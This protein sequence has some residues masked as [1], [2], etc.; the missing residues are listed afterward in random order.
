LIVAILPMVF[1]SAVQFDMEPSHDR[2]AENE[3]FDFEPSS[4]KDAENAIQFDFEPSTGK[5]EEVERQL[6]MIRSLGDIANRDM[7]NW[8]AEY[9]Q[10][11]ET[12]R[13]DKNASLC[14]D[15]EKL[16][17][18]LQQIREQVEKVRFGWDTKQVQ[19]QKIH[20]IMHHDDFKNVTGLFKALNKYLTEQEE[21]S[22]EEDIH[23]KQE[24]ADVEHEQHLLDTHPCPCIWGVWADWGQCSKM[25]GG[26]S[27]TRSRE[28][29]K[30]ATNNGDICEGSSFEQTSC[31]LE[32]CAIDCEW[33]MWGEWSDCSKA[34]GDGVLTRKRVHSIFAQYGGQNC[35]GEQ[36]VTQHCNVMDDLKKT[37]A[38]QEQTIKDL[39]DQLY[40]TVDCAWGEWS[41]WSECSKPCGGGVKSK[42]RVI[43]TE[44]KNGGKACSGNSM[45]SEQCNVHFCGESTTQAN[46]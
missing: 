42:S 9:D 26:G 45:E 21:Q 17:A 28:V 24:E 32:P 43:A 31:N 38:Q 34:C 12:Y 3:E 35:T 23:L 19:L 6:Q 1:G 37:I 27:K 36:Q 44:A 41:D 40:P 22:H 18:E 7:H 11:M 15:M 13:Q 30:Q 8:W 25:C 39:T 16:Q 14:I 2:D 20:E 29:A 33:G 4:E 5:G 46:R 10:M